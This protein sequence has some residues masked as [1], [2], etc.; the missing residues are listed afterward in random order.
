MRADA[1]KA[2]CSRGELRSYAQ[3]FAQGLRTTASLS[4]GD[5]VCLVSPNSLY[6]HLIVLG[7]QCAGVVFSGANASYTPTELAHQLADSSAK[8]VLAHPQ[9]L[10]TV[11]AATKSL[12]WSTS[13]QQRRIILAVRSDEAG[14]AAAK[15]KT[16]DYLLADKE[17][18]PVKVQ[19]PKNT[20]A[21]LGYS[22]GTSGKAKGVRTS[23][24]NMTVSA[25]SSC[26]ARAAS[27]DS[28]AAP[29]LCCRSSPRSRRT[30]TT[31]SSP[32]SLST[33]SRSPGGA[34]HAFPGR[35]W[36]DRSLLLTQTSTA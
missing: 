14:P 11:L 27:A 35:A 18:E 33:V 29:S 19:D 9:V 30:R 32:S 12:G 15:H 25:S 8:L 23:A 31:S 20:V 16:L 28:Q 36:A 24:Y 22:S 1:L 26:V 7:S 5:V 34:G 21:Y 3:R 2:W 6:Y 4:Q 13:D 17:M 10:D